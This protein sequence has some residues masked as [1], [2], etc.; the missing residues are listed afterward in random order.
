MTGTCGKSRATQ[1]NS[2]SRRVKQVADLKK[3]TKQTGALYY[4]GREAW[5]A[6]I[7]PLNYTRSEA[8]L[9]TDLRSVN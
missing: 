2:Q 9:G 6:G 3:K 5:E 8:S 1:G 7:L 4:L